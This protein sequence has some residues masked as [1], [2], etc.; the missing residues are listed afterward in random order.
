VYLI[1]GNRAEEQSHEASCTLIRHERQPL[2]KLPSA[3][4]LQI[5]PLIPG[6]ILSDFCSILLP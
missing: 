5:N 6:V 3:R 4:I 1:V 2:F